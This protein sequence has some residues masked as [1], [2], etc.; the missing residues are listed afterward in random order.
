MYLK[1][2]DCIKNSDVVIN[3]DFIQVIEKGKCLIYEGKY[4]I[5]MVN[6]TVYITSEEY[7]KLE[8]FLNV[9]NTELVENKYKEAPIHDERIQKLL[10]IGGDL[11]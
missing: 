8:T 11:K 5:H 4:L 6:K 10:N 9:Y 1:L 2:Y 3:T 7:K